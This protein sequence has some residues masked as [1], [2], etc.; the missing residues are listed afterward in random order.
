MTSVLISCSHTSYQCKEISIQVLFLFLNWVGFCAF[1]FMMTTLNCQIIL[2]SLSF[3][4]QLLIFFIQFEILFLDIMSV[5]YWC[6]DIGYYIMRIW[7]LFKP[8]VL[9][10]FHGQCSASGREVLP[11][12]CQMGVKSRFPIQSPLAPERKGFALLLGRGGS[13]GTPIGL[14]GWD[15]QECLKGAS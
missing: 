2:T 1:I 4:L 6:L 10:D 9:A 13:S 15:V 11:C 3:I 5:F 8:S 7:I 12:T 14:L